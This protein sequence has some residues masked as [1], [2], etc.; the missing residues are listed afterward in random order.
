MRRTILFLSAAAL[1]TSGLLAQER[2]EFLER[3]H[4][5]V[6]ERAQ[7]G[8]ANA[9]FA[10]GEFYYLGMGV[11][12]DLEKAMEYFERAAQKGHVKAA[13]NLGHISFERGEYDKARKWF[14]RAAE[15]K[16]PKSMLYLGEIHY[17]GLGVPQDYGKALYWYTKASE[18]G[19]PQAQYSLGMMFF[20]GKGVKR[21]YQQAAKLFEKAAEQEHAEAAYM[22]GK[23]YLEGLGVPKNMEL[24]KRYITQA[25]IDG[26]T[27]AKKIMEHYGWKATI[28]E[29]RLPGLEE[30]ETRPAL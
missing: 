12:K 15:A 16:D 20:E 10:L 26:H 5:A 14:E 8:D 24:A 11:P 2:A 21:D 30:N 23:M 1:M 25:Y 13:F 27:A 17:Q 28:P 18:A 22:L 7:T 19:Y 9:L 6:M 4:K 29:P 3:A